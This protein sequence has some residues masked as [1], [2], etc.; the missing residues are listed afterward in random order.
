MAA[1]HPGHGQHLTV[2][3]V[4]YWVKGCS[5]LG[6][7]RYAVL[8][9]VGHGRDEKLCLVDIK[10]VVQAA[11]PRASGAAMPGD[12]AVRVVEGAR[13]LA[14]FLGERM[15][16]GRLLGRPVVMRELLPQDLKLEIDQLSR[17][18]AV[19]A[20]RYL[21]SVIGQ[22]HAS[23]MDAAARGAWG[24]EL[25]RS[26]HVDGLDAP[27]WLWSSVVQLMAVHEAAYLEHC[28]AYA[29]DEDRRSA[30]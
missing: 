7:L 1:L 22:A 26:R 30:A 18:E 29:R 28:R 27:S 25:G 24:R 4:A 6:R 14:P 10:E 23:Q 9:G 2:H 16:A 20:A 19:E 5:S 15:L 8:L 21:A 13:S 11:A 12:D 3:D 17:K